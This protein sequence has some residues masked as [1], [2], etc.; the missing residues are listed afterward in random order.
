MCT[1]RGRL[2]KENV[3]IL[4]GDKVEL[5]DIKPEF[6]RRIYLLALSRKN[7]LS[8]PPLANIDQVIIVQAIHQPEW[9]PL[10]CD[11]YLVHFQLE[12]PDAS[13][14]LCFNKCDLADEEDMDTLRRTY[15]SLGY[16]LVIVSAYTGM[17]AWTSLRINWQA[18]F[19]FW[20]G[21][22]V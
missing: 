21:P 22:L 17:L 18:N 12:L 2:K 13:F 9:H 14:V 5:T 1:A 19:P 7:V 3:T 6:S 8:R 16:E 11:R 15:E 10:W 20:L 4:A